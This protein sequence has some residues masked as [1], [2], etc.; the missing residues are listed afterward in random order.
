MNLFSFILVTLSL[1]PSTF[2]VSAGI[3]YT[4]LHAIL[5]T[6]KRYLS[7]PKE[8]SRHA[9]MLGVQGM[10]TYK[11]A[12]ID[13]L[14]EHGLATPNPDVID[15][16]R[17]SSYNLFKNLPAM[18]DDV[19][20]MD[21]SPYEGANILHDMNL[22]LPF[23]GNGG[24]HQPK[25][26]YYDF[27]FDGGF[28]EHIYNAPQAFQNIINLLVAGGIVLSVTVNNNFSG[29]GFYQFSPEFFSRTFTEKNGMELLDIYLVEKDSDFSEWVKVDQDYKYRSTYRFPVKSGKVEGEEVEAKEVYIVAIARK[30]P[31]SS[32]VKSSATIDSILRDF[33]Q[34]RSYEEED[35]KK[36]SVH[37][38]EA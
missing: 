37:L 24:D 25:P 2:F 10:F 4:A 27:V 7:H 16:I 9:I 18:Y 12:F 8:G 28:T 14:T 3:D 31:F 11:Q 30:L 6:H 36:G 33:P 21:L 1:Y 26:G 29:H 34:Q 5:I 15:Y 32:S 22:P 20:S 13:V 23:D 19:D 17:A 38:Y 35:W